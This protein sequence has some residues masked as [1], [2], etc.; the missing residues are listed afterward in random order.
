MA[1]WKPTMYPGFSVM[2]G[3]WQHDKITTIH[4]K[5]VSGSSCNS[6]LQLCMLLNNI[7][8]HLE[9]NRAQFLQLFLLIKRAYQRCS[10]FTFILGYTHGGGRRRRGGLKQHRKT[11]KG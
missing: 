2:S 8:R 10:I 1:L 5:Q 9:A 3:F 6:H 7:W 11:D 4:L